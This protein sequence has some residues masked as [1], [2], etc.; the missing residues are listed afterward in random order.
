MELTEPK[1][2][3]NFKIHMNT[4]LPIVLKKDGSLHEMTGTFNEFSVLVECEADAKNLISR[5][6]FGKANLSRSYPQFVT[7]PELLRKRQFQTRTNISTSLSLVNNI[8]IIPDKVIVVPD[9]ESDDEYFTN[10]KPVYHMDNS[11]LREKL[12][13]SLEEAFFLASALKCLTV[14]FNDK[15]LSLK[16]M[17]K[18]F[19]KQHYF[20]RNYIVYFYYRSKNWI[21]KPGIK[22][23]GDFLLYKQGPPFYHASYVVIIEVIKGEEDSDKSARNID[24]FGLNR[25]CETAAKELIICKLFWAKENEVDFSDLSSIKILEILVRRWN[26]TQERLGIPK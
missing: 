2:K 19:S 15:K 14:Y 4:S 11:S 16:D 17:W 18:L 25:L 8:K 24:L 20:V 7:K 12:W 10:V 13:L 23:G 5:G 26:P 21:V 3:R 9:S 1:P 22:F 6:Y